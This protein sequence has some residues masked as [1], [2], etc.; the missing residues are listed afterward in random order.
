MATIPNWLNLDALIDEGL[1]TEL[2]AIRVEA[3]ALA[4]AVRQFSIRAFRA[5]WAWEAALHDQSLADEVWE[6][7]K[8]FSGAGAVFDAIRGL[9]DDLDLARLELPYGDSPEW[10]KRE[11]NS[12]TEAAR[13]IEIGSNL[14]PPEMPGGRTPTPVRS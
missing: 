2:E 10:Y 5:T 13:L 7:V 12:A 6:L 4:P 1:M 14:R 11:I 9:I 3:E 8:Q